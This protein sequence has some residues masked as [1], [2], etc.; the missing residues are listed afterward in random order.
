MAFIDKAKLY[1]GHLKPWEE[2]KRSNE[3]TDNEEESATTDTI[4]RNLDT[5]FVSCRIEGRDDNSL[6]I[7]KFLVIIIPAD[8]ART[9]TADSV[10]AKFK[11]VESLRLQKFWKAKKK[12]K[13]KNANVLE[14]RFI[15]T[16]KNIGTQNEAINVRFVAQGFSDKDE[17]LMVYD[18]TALRPS[19]I[20][21]IFST[22]A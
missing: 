12:S 6:T 15:H 3:D 4:T 18:S 20:R 8:K 11:K 17:Q 16:L 21:L 22:A 1:R 10:E 14:G 13:I 2:P 5:M 19:S 7:Y 9:S